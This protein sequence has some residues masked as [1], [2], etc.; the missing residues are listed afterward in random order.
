[1]MTNSQRKNTIARAIEHLEHAKERTRHGYLTIAAMHITQARGY[2]VCLCDDIGDD[3]DQRHPDQDDN[4]Y[5]W[6][7]VPDLPDGGAGREI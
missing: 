7:P 4:G 3:N 1:M 5:D 6:K 2:M